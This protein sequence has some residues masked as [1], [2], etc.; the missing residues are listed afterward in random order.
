MSDVLADSRD[1]LIARQGEGIADLGVADDAGDVVLAA[2]PLQHRLR[3]TDPHQQGRAQISQSPT[4][5]FKTF[6]GESPLSGRCVGQCP[7]VRL[8]NI[9]R[10]N[11]TQTR[12]IGQRG[13][14]TDAQIAFEPNENIHGTYQ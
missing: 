10:Q 4:Q 2:E 8:D 13:M 1:A 11:R 9:K 14:V 5:I 12:C 7:I 6:C 3:I